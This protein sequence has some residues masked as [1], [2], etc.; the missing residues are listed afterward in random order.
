[1]G[2]KYDERRTQRKQLSGVTTLPAMP[3][4]R[5]GGWPIQARFWLEWGRC[6]E[7]GQ[8]PASKWHYLAHRKPATP[9]N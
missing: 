4:W 3:A 5:A 8:H 9:V 6:R 2:S 7:P 1:M